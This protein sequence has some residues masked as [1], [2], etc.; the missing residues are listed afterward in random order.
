MQNLCSLTIYV[1]AVATLALVSV[2][3]AA[4]LP[5]GRVYELVSSPP[6]GHD[7]DVYVQST[8]EDLTNNQEHGIRTALPFEV[9][10]SGEAVVYAGD[11]PVTGGTG[12]VGEANGNEYLAR[13]LPEGGWTQAALEGDDTGKYVDFS[14]DLSVGFTGGGEVPGSGTPPGYFDW[15]AHATANGAEGEYHPFFT[16]TPDRSSRELRFAQGGGEGER[17]AGGNSGTNAVPAFTNLLFEA[18]GGIL[19]GEGQLEKELD[20]DVEQEV[21]E[22]R[23]SKF[24]HYLYDTVAGQP[25]LVDMLPDGRVAPGATYGSLE[26]E[27]SIG[28][29]NPDLTHVISADGSRIFWTWAPNVEET[30]GPVLNRSEGIYVRENPTQPQSPLNGDECTVPADACTVQVAPSGSI[31]QTASADGSKVFF[32]NVNEEL[33]EY[34][35]ETGETTELAPG[36]K[37]AGVAGTSEDGEYVYYVDAKGN[38]ELWHDSATTLVAAEAGLSG[39]SPYLSGIGG[40]GFH[41]DYITELGSRT[42]EVTPDGHSLIFMSTARL[43]GY[44]NVLEGAPPVGSMPLD[45]VFLYEAEAGRLTCVSCNPS[46][47]PPV[48]VEA[49]TAIESSGQLVGAFFPISGQPTYQPQSIA[50]DGSRVFFDSAEPLVPQDQNGWI[51]VY[52][53]ERDGVGSC[54]SSGGCIYLLSG[55]TDR[56][57]SYLIGASASGDDVFFISR[58]Q[59]TRADDGSD[60]SVVYDARVNG[61]QPPAPPLCSGTGCQGVPPPPPI[62][63]TPASVTFNGPGN[64]SPPPPVEVAKRT[65]KCRAGK[66]LSHGRCVKARTAKRKMKGRT[67]RVKRV[68]KADQRGGG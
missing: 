62:F 1:T 4:G 35:L 25:H 59:L 15:Y 22:G 65:V 5:D 49:E 30:G 36:V 12:S 31:F 3:P 19:E 21:K 68:T 56:E 40:E 44:D 42:A 37:V 39:V 66:K 52:E 54:T 16:A 50:A 28:Y 61:Y 38:I 9:A 64:F 11:P 26:G 34:D 29:T 6:G 33:D 63:A 18:N 51:D 7:V 8:I 20:E 53:W 46:G 10:P 47:Q 45:E 23:D 13:H 57:N 58:A 48:R 24:V 27:T 17:Y 67:K 14:S 60:D 41:G 32:T 2:S 55:G 43:T